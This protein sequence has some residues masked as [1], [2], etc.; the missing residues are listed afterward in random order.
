MSSHMKDVHYCARI[1][2]LFRLSEDIW[3]GL[4]W[5]AIQH[6]F[7]WVN[8]EPLWEEHWYTGEPNCMESS[9]VNCSFKLLNQSCVRLSVTQRLHWKT[10]TCNG[11]YDFLCQK[12]KLSNT[13]G[14]HQYIKSTPEYYPVDSLLYKM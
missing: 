1:L 6:G 2:Y 9:G 5:N 13:C 7:L 4:I 12:C 3:I 10:Y 11:Q 14:K 8:N